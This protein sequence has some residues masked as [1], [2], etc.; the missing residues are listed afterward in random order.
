LNHPVQVNTWEPLI[1]CIKNIAAK[2]G[3]KQLGDQQAPLVDEAEN[4]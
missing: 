1:Q 2:K 4:V 3:M